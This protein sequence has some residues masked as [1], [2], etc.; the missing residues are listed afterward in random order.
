MPRVQNAGT[1]RATAEIQDRVSD[2]LRQIDRQIAGL[3][4]GGA[5]SLL[6]FASI[7]GG[8]LASVGAA[9]L[10]AGQE[11][12]EALD[13]IATGTGAT[14][15]ALEGLGDDLEGALGTSSTSAADLASA[16]AALNTAT[17]ETGEGLT[18]A[19]AAAGRFAQVFEVDAGATAKT[20]GQILQQFNLDAADT[21]HV[22]D[23]ATAASQRY[24]VGASAVLEQVR[25]FGPV[26]ENAGFGL[27]QTV[28]LFGRLESVGIDVTR[29]MPGLNGAIRR[30]AR[31]GVTDLDGAINSAIEQIR[32]LD[33]ESE[34]LSIAE[35]TFGAEGAARLVAAIRDGAIPAVSELGTEF[36]DAAGSLVATQREVTTW[37]DLASAS[38]GRVVG[39]VGGLFDLS[40]PDWLTRLLI[41]GR[42]SDISIDVNLPDPDALDLGNL[43]DVRQG[44]R[45]TATEIGQADLKLAALQERLDALEG[46][47]AFSSQAPVIREQI[48]ATE[49]A[50]GALVD[51][52]AALE[53]VAEVASGAVGPVLETAEANAAAASEYAKATGAI[54]AQILTLP[55]VTERLRRLQA[56]HALSARNAELDARAQRAFRD[57][58]EV[59]TLAA[60]PAFVALDD[61]SE[62]AERLRRANEPLASTTLDLGNAYETLGPGVER[63]TRLLRAAVSP[64]EALA[65]A[66]E[67]AA[68]RAL[69]AAEAQT[70]LGASLQDTGGAISRFGSTV[71]NVDPTIGR[72]IGG[73]G[74]ATESVGNLL[75]AVASGAASGPLGVLNVG[76]SVASGLFGFFAGGASEADRE[77]EK[78]NEEQRETVDLLADVQSGAIS[79]GDAL[80]QF[81]DN[82]E[83]AAF[84]QQ[85]IN[86]FLP[87]ISREQF[88][89]LRQFEADLISI[90][91]SA[92][93][94]AAEV[95]AIA[96]DGIIDESERQRIADVAQSANDLAD[97][98]DRARENADSAAD[99][100]LRLVAN[101]DARNP[102]DR[103]FA[104]ASAALDGLGTD[105]ES[106][107]GDALSA[108]D[109]SEAFQRSQLRPEDVTRAA[110]VFGIGAGLEGEG[111][112]T[113]LLRELG[114][115]DFSAIF[116]TAALTDY[117]TALDTLALS[118]V[119]AFEVLA[120]ASDE[121]R[122]ALFGTIEAAV[123]AGQSIPTALQPII[124]A[125]REQLATQMMLNE[126]EQRELDLL[127]SLPDDAYSDL[128][129]DQQI[130]LTGVSAIIEALGRDVPDA[131]RNLLN[132]AVESAADTGAMGAEAITAAYDDADAERVASADDA[133]SELIALDRER[134]D[135]AVQEW[136][137]ERDAAAGVLDD[138]RS[139]IDSLPGD[140][141]LDLNV[142]VSTTTDGSPVSDAVL[143]A[144]ADRLPDELRRR[145]Y[146]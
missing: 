136:E 72:F 97:G 116:D 28:S 67:E 20:T 83:Y 53:R 102:F 117:A 104:D 60:R 76:L 108:A 69:Q 90:G 57:A 45:D 101:L 124:E 29:V 2:P 84:Q 143:G 78:F 17:G 87:D 43:D 93:D 1:L 138:V 119:D 109:L 130:F 79:A 123:N 14:G 11:Y 44:I 75:A 7:G 12:T 121:Q 27:E 100:G 51:Y 142:R 128:T 19:T 15:A 74:L 3:A 64:S 106:V 77:L 144:V 13:I 140:R 113:D 32:S 81:A 54:A 139:M 9:A 126:A 99:A 18:T 125:R 33:S 56:Q 26:L 134:V 103:W 94:A 36:D 71:G 82:A 34:A 21:E 50:R 68:Q 62:A 133:T 92:E 135:Q 16:L 73:I 114:G 146:I 35:R 40:P 30:L 145:G 91:V 66:E 39:A 85:R 38:W 8:A 86:E 89:V 115:A 41:D 58:L 46:T 25:Q 24:G 6:R 120:N 112:Q 5:S 107:L 122:A 37:A 118:G 22:L 127:N 98:L 129:R 55:T 10:A 23:L 131:I 65:Q 137:R 132:P 70:V 111:A 4:G 141:T 47:R 88:D 42:L 61:T 31:D 48:Q 63:A 95:D 110:D 59:V 52:Q 49:D 105:I 80:Q 96:A